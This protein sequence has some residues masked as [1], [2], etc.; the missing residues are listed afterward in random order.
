M[1]ESNFYYYY[2]NP[3]Q[4]KYF[5]DG[6]YHGAV[7]FRDILIDGRTGE[8]YNINELLKSICKTYSIDAARAIIELE[9]YSLDDV[10]VFG[11]SA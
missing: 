2:D 3:V 8:V 7:A 1:D 9:W 11:Q 6:T 4:V 10:I 5:Y